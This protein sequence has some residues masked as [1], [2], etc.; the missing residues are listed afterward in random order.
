[1]KALVV[2]SGIAGLAAAVALKRANVSV[3]VYERAAEIREL[4][5]ALSVWANGVNALHLLG[6]KG[7][8][9]AASASIRR[10]VALT[11]SGAVLSRTNLEALG[12]RHGSE[13]VCI[14]RG[15]LQRILLHAAGPA[16]VHTGKTCTAI[17]QTV[18]SAQASFE[19]GTVAEADF[20]VAADGIGSTIRTQLHPE[21]RPRPAGYTAWR[22]MTPGA[23][24]E[25][26]DGTAL[27][28]LGRGCQAGIFPCGSQRVYWFATQKAAA[29]PALSPEAR[30]RWILDKFRRWPTS[31][32]AVVEATSAEAILEHDISDLEPLRRWGAGRIT[33]A[34]DAI[35][36][37]TPNLGQ[38]AVLAIE[39]AV[40][41]GRCVESHG[42]DIAAALRA[43]ERNRQSRTAWAARESR[44]AGRLLHAESATGTKLRE[45]LM[46]SRPG[47]WHGERLLRRLFEFAG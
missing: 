10:T 38:G 20:L 41:L 28:I 47:Q 6:V 14:E 1:M 31:L 42:G 40:V 9:L 37:I 8:V 30:K 39:D 21:S 18:D 33:L 2:G 17:R 26:H 35:H 22:A 4:G 23:F 32:P 12:R 16:N 44:R 24:A 5:A 7:E 29:N 3:S 25:L 11:E 43:Y 36:A 19:D 27:L 15:E 34:G 46:S 13:S 45:W